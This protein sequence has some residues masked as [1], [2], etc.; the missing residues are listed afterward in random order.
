[1]DTIQDRRVIRLISRRQFF[2]ISIMMLALLFM[3][4]FSLVIK[5]HG[6]QYDTNEHLVETVGS[7]ETAWEIKKIDF[8]NIFPEKRD[9][10]LFIGS[11]NSRIGSVV[12]QWCTYTKR[13]WAVTQD[14]TKYRDKLTIWPEIILVE[15]EY[16]NMESD[17]EILRNFAEQGMN[18]IFCNLPSV[19]IIEENAQLQE[20]LGISGVRAAEVK[21]E[22]IK[23]FKGMLLG[24]EVVYESGKSAS[25]G[26][27][28]RF[29]WYITGS[30]TK[31]YMV[32]M[33]KDETVKN[34][35]LPA[36]IWRNSVGNG[37]V[38]AVNGTYLY[39]SAGL[40]FLSGMLAEVNPVEIYPI[41]NAQNL[42]VVNYPGFASENDEEMQRIYSRTQSGVFRDTVW[43]SLVSTVQNSDMKL[44][45]FVMPQFDY[46]D[47]NEPEGD[48]LIFYLKQFKEVGAEAG[49][50]LEY[51]S[52]VSLA[53]KIR[54][55]NIFFALLNSNYQYGTAYVEVAKVPVLLKM[56]DKVM[57]KNIGTIV[58]EY[59]ENNPVVSY[60][61]DNV[62][63]QCTTNDGFSHTHIENLRMRSLESALGYTNIVL[64]MK[65]VAWPESD[66]D[67]WQIIYKR[68]AS[69]IETY[70]SSYKIFRNTTLSESN[71]NVKD[72][73]NMDFE[74]VYQDGVLRVNLSNQTG[75]NW[76]IL[77]T[78][79][80]SIV[81]I[82]GGTFEQI[83]ENAYLIEATDSE[84]VI[85]LDR[86][87]EF[88]YYLP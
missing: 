55:D 28:F 38:F 80:E 33:L 2:S 27:D 8:K 3:F 86:E 14:L 25:V 18:I 23:I 76:F 84:L 48:E 47:E 74:K 60:C 64:D 39:D 75:T 31:T 11:E 32:G 12:N 68:F 69:N 83:E 42:S 66:A 54:R 17:L 6:N 58:C 71:R 21:V 19:E 30:G 5:E 87:E 35:Q 85:E 13:D 37:K 4:Q 41:I 57:L 7:I 81:D 22:A 24:G 40:G 88:Y 79:G 77:R 67:H 20:L 53:D 72:F 16:I 52:G 9:Y 61:A 70:W 56:M 45:C 29:P 34:E 82:S 43:P 78:H 63:L 50:S 62:T 26:M 46:N 73:L 51:G 59:N 36:L 44:T 1:M 10:V 49:I 15:S 65:K